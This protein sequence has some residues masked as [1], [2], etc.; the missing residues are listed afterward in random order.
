MPRTLLLPL[1]L[2]MATLARAQGLGDLAVNPTRVILEG[3][4]RTAEVL[5]TNKGREA[6]TYRVSFIHTRMDEAGNVTECEKEPGQAT[7]EDL[8]RYSPREVKLAPGVTQ[9]VRIQLRKPEDLAAGEYR[10]Q[11][12]FR[13]VPPAQELNPTAEEDGKEELSISI[14]PIYGISIPV[15]VRQGETS[16]QAALEAPALGAPTKDGSPVVNLRVLREGNMS[17]GGTLEATWTPAGGKP[18]PAGEM[19]CSVYCPL[20]FIRVALPLDKLAGKD[21]KG[22][23]LKVCF[24]PRDAKAPVA[25]TILELP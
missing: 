8:V 18:V 19:P 10:A 20:P 1:F 14:R 12:L 11:M 5:L 24:T 21:L 7:A 3:R 17:M 22:G 6:A 9:V 23:I 13:A 2:L 15:V 16:F 25:Q 4:T